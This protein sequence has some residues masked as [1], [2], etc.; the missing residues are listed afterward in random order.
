[1]RRGGPAPQELLQKWLPECS[2]EAYRFSRQSPSQRLHLLVY[3]I[4]ELMKERRAKGMS[5]VRFLLEV[6]LLADMVGRTGV[7]AVQVTQGFSKA[8]LKAFPRGGIP[9]LRVPASRPSL[10]NKDSSSHRLAGPES[11]AVRRSRLSLFT[12]NPSPGTTR[13]RAGDWLHSLLQLTEVGLQASAWEVS[14]AVS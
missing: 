13:R 2:S 12:G 7:G 3:C 11:S 9:M 4:Q 1:M 5:D 6:N 14:T 10:R 8:P